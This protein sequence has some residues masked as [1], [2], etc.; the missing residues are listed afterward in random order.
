MCIYI[1]SLYIAYLYNV[2][3]LNYY[4]SVILKEVYVSM[5]IHIYL[6]P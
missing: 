5:P 1:L 6:I 2:I 3:F 4:L